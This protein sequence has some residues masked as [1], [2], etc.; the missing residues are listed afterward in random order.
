MLVTRVALAVLIRKRVNEED[1]LL[2]EKS[3]TIPR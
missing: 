1:F 2:M 3:I